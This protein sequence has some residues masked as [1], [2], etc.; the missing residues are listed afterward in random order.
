MHELG[1]TK[2]LL[3]IAHQFPPIAGGGVFRP[4]KFAQYLPKFG[5]EPVILTV[6]PA[7]EDTLDT[8]LLT[9]LSPSVMVH[10]VD[11]LHPKRIERLALRIWLTLW[12]ARL[13]FVARKLEPFK[14]MRWLLPDAYFSW[15]LPGYLAARRVIREHQIDVV[16]TT[17]P[18][19]SSPMIGLGLRRTVGT[20]WIADYRDPW[21]QNPFIKFPTIV[22]RMLVQRWDKAVMRSADI[23]LSTTEL[24]TANLLRLCDDRNEDKV[25]TIWNGFDRTEF[26]AETIRGSQADRFVISHV[27]SLYELRRAD[28]FLNVV[29]TLVDAG[30]IPSDRLN[31]CFMGK[32]GT[33]VV[34]RYPDKPW[35]THYDSAA[36]GEAIAQ[37][38]ASDVLLLLVNEGSEA[39]VP[40]KLYE[41]LASQKPI[42]AVAPPNSEAARII[43]Q[44]GMGIVVSHEE[45]SALG[46]VLEQGY[47]KWKNGEPP[48][49][50]RPNAE[51]INTFDRRS[52]AQQL[53]KYL[54]ELSPLYPCGSTTR[55]R[56]AR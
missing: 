28:G 46:T 12:R 39:Q 16:M 51:I 3:I 6:K 38:N 41:Y 40:G 10:R 4:L 42:L 53:A 19:F 8:T 11:Y 35:F 47:R 23:V 45:I 50:I 44:T 13:R 49:S 1:R 27:G 7:P 5:W 37:M 20:P 36:H 24:M 2:R 9:E 33:G 29:Q 48:F 18:P 25:R 34:Q 56:N 22:H 30:E 14:V 26:S 54:D 52:Q 31:I 55:L 15:L 21:S 43:Q 32:D 17:A